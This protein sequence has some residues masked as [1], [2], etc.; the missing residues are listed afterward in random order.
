LNSWIR[1]FPIASKPNMSSGAPS[2]ACYDRKGRTP[3][4]IGDTSLPV[5]LLSSAIHNPESKSPGNKLEWSR[6]DSE[7]Y[8]VC[9]GQQYSRGMHPRAAERRDALANTHAGRMPSYSSPFFQRPVSTDR[10]DNCRIRLQGAQRHVTLGGTHEEGV[11]SC[12]SPFFQRPVGTD[13]PRDDGIH[14]Q[15]A[16]EHV[17]LDDAHDERMPSYLPFFRRPVGSDQPYDHRVSPQ[18]AERH[19]A[20]GDPHDKS[21]PSFLTSLL[22]TAEKNTFIHFDVD[23]SSDEDAAYQVRKIKSAPTR[24]SANL[25]PLRQ[26]SCLLMPHPDDSAD[27]FDKGRALQGSPLLCEDAVQA[28][29]DE[30]VRSLP[31]VGSAEHASG[32]CKPCAWFWKRQGCRNGEDCRHCHLCPETELKRRKKEKVQAIR[33][34]EHTS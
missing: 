27:C 9:T 21:L 13:Q 18:G 17:A 31:S 19:V 12:S 29:N 15:G 7:H 34:Q 6:E 10:Q 33:Q 14:F 16:D 5:L 26:P 25:Q 2:Q 22:A 24:N 32:N 23:S 11:P 1:P 28:S 8:P 4:A 20:L 3:I 30:V